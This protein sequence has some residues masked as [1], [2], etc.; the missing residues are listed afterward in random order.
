MN[1]ITSFLVILMYPFLKVLECLMFA[2]DKL[3]R[4]KIKRR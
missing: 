3:N 4:Q 2:Y 1:K